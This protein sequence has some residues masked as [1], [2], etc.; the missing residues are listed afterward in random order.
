[1]CACP[2]LAC[3]SQAA[4][5]YPHGL[6]NLST[7]ENAE[8]VQLNRCA[9]VGVTPWNQVVADVSASRCQPVV[10]HCCALLDVRLAPVASRAMGASFRYYW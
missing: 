2:P 1:M 4:C 3:L 8:G 5:I 9:L 6:F 10:M 7:Q